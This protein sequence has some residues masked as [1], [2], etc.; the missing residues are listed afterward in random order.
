MAKFV[1]FKINNATAPGAG[2]NWGGRDVLIGVD[3][4]ENVSDVVSGGGAYSVV[5]TLKSFVGLSDAAIANATI[6]GRILTLTVSTSLS[7]AVDPT[8][9]TVD[10]NMPSQSIVRA[11]TA[12]PGG[13][14]ASAQLGL[15]GGGVRATDDQMYWSGAVFSSVN[16]I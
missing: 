13:I 11:M 1:K 15:D 14:A 5:V 6:G 2:G 12:N 16:D 3:D 8:A 9:V 10:G 7:A 4:I